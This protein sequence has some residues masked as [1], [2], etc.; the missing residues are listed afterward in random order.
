MST[1]KPQFSERARA[2]LQEK[3]FAVLA[4][5]QND[6]TPQLTTMWYML[7]GNTIVMNTKA[8]RFKEHNIRRD[9][10]VAICWEDDYNYLSVNGIAEIIDDPQTTQQDIYRLAARYHGEEGARQQMQESFS[11]EQRVTFRITCD[12][13]IERLD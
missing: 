12:H 9:P 11:Q 6:G 2:F 10:R 7:E 13:I 3:R 5:I 8:G 1:H 4:T